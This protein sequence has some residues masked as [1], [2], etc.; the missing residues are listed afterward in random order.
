M[1]MKWRY[2]EFCSAQVDVRHAWEEVMPRNSATYFL[3]RSFRVLV[4]Y[5]IVF[6]K[7]YYLTNQSAHPNLIL[8]IPQRLS[9]APLQYPTKSIGPTRGFF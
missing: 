9:H 4:V 6:A 3:F 2:L 5:E 8:Q 7:T 1:A